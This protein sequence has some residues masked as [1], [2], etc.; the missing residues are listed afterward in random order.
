MRARLLTGKGLYGVPAPAKINLF[1]HVTG[2]RD[3]GYHDLQTVFRF[4]GLYD[5][6]DFDVRA[7]GRIVREGRSLPGVALRD[8]LIVRA[9]R[10]LQKATGTRLGVQMRLIKQ[11]PAGGGLGGGSSDA[12]TVLIALN[13]LWGTGL[14][15]K[16]LQSLGAELGA[17]VPVFI[18]GRPAFA[19]GRGDRFTSLSLPPA[20][21]VIIQPRVHLATAQVFADPGLTRDTKPVTI[22]FFTEWQSSAPR[23]AFGRNDLEPA[24]GRISP[25]VAQLAG[26]LADEGFTA[27]MSGSGSCFFV[28]CASARQAGVIR[29]A[30]LGKIAAATQQGYPERVRQVWAV[31]GLQAHPL[32]AWLQD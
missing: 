1:L 24:A 8:D 21:Y 18:F 7:D 29:Q 13:R 25:E 17:D 22:S 14:D 28:E 31:P 19:E 11:I 15:R 12:A 23:H 32:Y 27:R 10:L 16:R 6:L 3:D 9:A 20:Y 4:I 2:R 5:W 26:W 30:I